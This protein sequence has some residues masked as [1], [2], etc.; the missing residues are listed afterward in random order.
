[1]V[2]YT[3]QHWYNDLIRSLFAGL[4]RL[5]YNLLSAIYQIFFNV[6]TADVL[7][8]D[9]VKSLFGRIQ[10]ILGIVIMFKLVIGLFNGIMNPDSFKDTKSGF[11]GILK[12]IVVVLFLMVLMVP[13]NIPSSDVGDEGQKSWNKNLNTHGVIFGSLYEL[14]KRVLKGDVIPRLILGAD[15][16]GEMDTEGELFATDILRSLLTVNVVEDGADISDECDDSDTLCVCEY[17]AEEDAYD[18]YFDN[19]STVSEIL[20]GKVVNGWCRYSGNMSDAAKDNNFDYDAYAFSYSWFW[21]TIIGVLF[22][23]LILSLAVDTAI[24][25]FKLA[26]LEIVSPIPIL[27]YIDPKGEKTFQNWVKSVSTTYLSVFI[28]ISIISF[29]L[30]VIRAISARGFGIE[31]EAGFVGLVSKILIYIALIMFAKE[32]PKFI[33]DTLGI[34]RKEGE[35][36]FSGIGKLKSAVGRTAATIT[37]GI[38]SMRNG[39]RSSMAATDANNANGNGSNPRHISSMLKAAGAAAVNGVGGAHQASSAYGQ[40]KD[41]KWRTAL[42][43]VNR[44]NAYRLENAAA[45]GT[46]WGKTKDQLRQDFTGDSEYHQL[47]RKEKALKDSMERHNALSKQIGDLKTAAEAEVNKKGVNFAISYKDQHG[48]DHNLVGNTKDIEAAQEN[49]KRT[50]RF[51]FTDKSG[52]LHTFASAAEFSS[53]MA[54]AFDNAMDQYYAGTAK[55]YNGNDLK[56]SDNIKIEAMYTAVKNGMAEYDGKYHVSGYASGNGMRDNMKVVSAYA[57]TQALKDQAEISS[58]QVEK[59]KAQANYRGD[60][61][62]AGRR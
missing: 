42:D 31:T 44:A 34:E 13:L 60:D 41:H 14:Q 26:I 47:A 37:G 9:A 19:S 25:I 45:G 6:A 35:G 5:V 11:S 10:L 59:S 1:M 8:G 48:V 23:I 54:Q 18:I 56:Y 17:D 36:L 21:S 61:G 50:G 30:F 15:S 28:R 22:C 51:E 52:T 20:S 32:A 2:D 33:T 57:D 7:T 53:V 16:F 24:R 12:R 3:E 39:Y 49:A 55:M 62:H 40:A 58:T 46:W 4:D 43:Q 38:S 29:I 27:S